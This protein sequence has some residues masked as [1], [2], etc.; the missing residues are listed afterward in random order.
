ML[1]GKAMIRTLTVAASFVAAFA[2]CSTEPEE[3]AVAPVAPEP[4]EP[5]AKPDPYRS[6]AE[7]LVAAIDGGMDA[8][9]VL[10]L[11]DALT[12]TGMAM[13]PGL[14]EEH[15][16][17][18]EYLEAIAA[19]GGSLRDMPLA[20]IETGYHNDGKLPTMP[21]ADCYHGKDLV[22]HPATVSAMAKLG[23][24][25]DEERQ[26]AK[27]EI[28]EVLGHLTAIEPQKGE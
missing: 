12:S 11:A 21:S 10:V 8:G 23:L 19:V 3:K 4:V 1:E 27:G 16:A 5:E 2:S 15:P 20:D 9:Q 22:V 25:T 7:A 14:I 18:K 28:V 26:S 6:Q 17:C 24:A 13:L